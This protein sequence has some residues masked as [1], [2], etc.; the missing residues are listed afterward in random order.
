[1]IFPM[2]VSYIDVVFSDSE[3]E[4]FGVNYQ[5]VND[6]HIGRILN[7]PSI[8]VIKL[9]LVNRIARFI[10]ISLI[11]HIHYEEL[12]CYNFHLSV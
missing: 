1:M 4:S 9:T 12:F 5:L 3:E 2:N 7:R 11:L 6:V 10:L 8:L